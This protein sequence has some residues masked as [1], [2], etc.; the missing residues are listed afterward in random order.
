VSNIDTA[1]EALSTVGTGGVTTAVGTM[2][3]GIGTIT[4]TFT[5]GNL[6][7]KLLSVMTADATSLTGTVPTVSV[8]VTT[9]GVDATY[10][11]LGAGAVVVD[12]TNK[13]LYINTG[14][15]LAPTWTKVGT[16]T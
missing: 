12:T 10:R 15:A 6:T 14:S 7:K 5:G 3:A 13:L 1:L 11:G 2:T 9:P 8:A 4:A 16:Q